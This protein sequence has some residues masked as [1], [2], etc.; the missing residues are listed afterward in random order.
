MLQGDY[1][2]A[3]NQEVLQLF[4]YLA[5]TGIR[6]LYIIGKHGPVRN[7]KGICSFC[8]SEMAAQQKKKKR[9]QQLQCFNCLSQ[10]AANILN[11]KLQP[12][13]I[14][15]GLSELHILSI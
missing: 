4:L 1:I 14:S 11:L 2:T 6:R 15:F 3:G 13:P 5:E 7:Q 9:A 10:L 12:K 8:C